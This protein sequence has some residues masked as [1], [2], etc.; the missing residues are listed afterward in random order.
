M[1]SAMGITTLEQIIRISVA[2]VVGSLIGL[3]RKRLHKAAGVRTHAVVTV[4]C[5][6]LTIV[7]VYGFNGLPGNIDPTRLLSNIITG[8]GF[9]AGGT[10]FVATKKRSNSMEES[11]VGLTTAAGI[12]GAAMLGIPIGLGHFDLVLITIVAIEISLQAER[13]LKKIHLINDD[14]MKNELKTDKNEI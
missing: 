11:V 7:S 14:K 5:T 4:I 1:S 12:F 6:M 9:L 10:I 8:V 3:E 2:I 13:V